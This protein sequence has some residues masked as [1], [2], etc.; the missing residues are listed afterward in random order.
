MY[1]IYPIIQFLQLIII[2]S[3]FNVLV[4]RDIIVSVNLIFVEIQ[5]AN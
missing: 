5:G 3:I 4:E 1:P 2:N